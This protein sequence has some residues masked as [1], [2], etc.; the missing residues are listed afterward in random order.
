MVI[1]GFNLASADYRSVR[2]QRSLAAGVAGVL[3]LALLAQTAAWLQVRHD[4]GA[5]GRRIVELEARVQ[6]QGA[7]GAARSARPSAEAKALEARVAAYNR[8]LEAA[9]FSWSGLLFELE[10]AVPPHVELRDI[11]PDPAS[12]KVTLAGVTRSFEDVSALVRALSQR[13]AFREVYLLREAEARP[14]AGAPTRKEV[15]FTVTMLYAGRAG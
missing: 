7:A 5:L 2:R 12:G 9:A 13:A 11:Q 6:R 4:A 1:R 8:I 14:E 15:S 10:Q 3:V